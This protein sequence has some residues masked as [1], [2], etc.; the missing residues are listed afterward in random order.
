MVQILDCGYILGLSNT[1][2][3]KL[4]IKCFDGSP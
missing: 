3:M 1:P 4:G 2:Y